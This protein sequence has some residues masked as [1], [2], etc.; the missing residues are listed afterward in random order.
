[1]KNSVSGGQVTTY[2]IWIYAHLPLAVGLTA[3]GVGITQAVLHPPGLPL[4]SAIRWITF[5]SMAICFL[6]LAAIHL[7]TISP[8]VKH[9]KELGANYRV[10]AA[11]LMLALA[12]SRLTISPVALTGILALS[13]AVM[14]VIDFYER[15]Q[16]EGG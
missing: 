3:I 14:V 7:T 1:M 16:H 13:C 15:Q 8:G 11:V 5:A 2:Q 4:P 9:P 12:A 6:S 10:A